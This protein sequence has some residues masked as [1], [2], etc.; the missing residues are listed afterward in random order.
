MPRSTFAL[1]LAMFVTAPFL[2]DIGAQSAPTPSAALSLTRMPQLASN[3]FPGDFNRDSRTD[4]IAGGTTSGG[5]PS[6]VLATGAGNGAFA[7]PRALGIAAVPFA[8]SDINADGRQ[9]VIVGASG[10]VSVLP[11]NGDGTFGALRHVDT[12]VGIPGSAAVVADFNGDTHRDLVVSAPDAAGNQGLAIYPG[13][14][15]LTRLARACSY[16]GCPTVQPA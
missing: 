10:N 8:V 15:D 7:A 11:G 3:A 4:L 14:G 9:D 13:N 2:L 1:A 12:G 16:R 6:L 5:A